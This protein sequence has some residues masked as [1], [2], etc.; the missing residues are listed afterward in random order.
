[1]SD[2]EAQI[3]GLIDNFRTIYRAMA[4]IMPSFLSELNVTYTQMLILGCVK[5]NKGINLRE[6]SAAMGITSSA[7]A[8]QVN[9]LVKRGFLVREENTPD[10]RFIKIRL[11]RE[12][13]KQFGVL[14]A[15][16]YEQSATLFDGISDDELARYCELHGMMVDQITEGCAVLRRQ[17]DQSPA[18]G[19]KVPPAARRRAG[20]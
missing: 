12:M 6:L 11:S 14:R 20:K 7:A 9:N 18:S 4:K 2:R 17:A 19:R 16:F 10:R 3:I 1:M 13:Q 8:Q 5:E 15:R